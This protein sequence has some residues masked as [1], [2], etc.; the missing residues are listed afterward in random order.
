[1]GQ[2]MKGEAPKFYSREFAAP[3]KMLWRD[4][5]RTL[6]RLKKNM[7]KIEA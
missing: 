7:E 3:Q 4:L 2:T 1:M 5:L 6:Y